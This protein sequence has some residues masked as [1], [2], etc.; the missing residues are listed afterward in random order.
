MDQDLSEQHRI[1]VS[2]LEQARANGYPFPNDVR[3]DFSC[4]SFRDKIESEAALEVEQRQVVFLAGRI[5][6]MRLMGKAAF[7]QLQDA[8]GAIQFYIR[9]DDVSEQDFAVFKE[10]DL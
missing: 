4:I 10:L 3:V 7:C 1:R 5:I 6:A 8:S 2:K 9:K